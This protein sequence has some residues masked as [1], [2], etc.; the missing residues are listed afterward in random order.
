VGRDRADVAGEFPDVNWDKMLMN[1]MIMRVV[2]RP[3]MLD[4]IVAIPRV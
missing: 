3:Q 1:V 4:T 2:L